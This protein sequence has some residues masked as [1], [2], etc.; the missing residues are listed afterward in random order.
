M[1]HSSSHPLIHILLQNEEAIAD[2][3]GQQYTKHK[4]SEKTLKLSN[5]K[6]NSSSN[7][8]FN[9]QIIHGETKWRLKQEAAKNIKQKRKRDKHSIKLE[10]TTIPEGMRNTFTQPV[11]HLNS[12]IYDSTSQLTHPLHDVTSSID[13]DSDSTLSSVATLPST[14]SIISS[15]ENLISSHL[16][17][18]CSSSPCKC[19][20]TFPRITSPLQQQQQTEPNQTISESISNSK[21]NSVLPILFPLRNV[22]SSDSTYN[23]WINFKEN[24]DILSP[25]AQQRKLF[26]LLKKSEQEIITEKSNKFASEGRTKLGST[27]HPDTAFQQRKILI[28][29]VNEIMLD[30]Q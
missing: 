8:Q 26:R 27:Q 6:T 19:S 1:L 5:N 14:A 2:I 11:Q 3:I 10:T 29:T 22:S 12:A 13:V 20:L 25:S 4:Q 28:M 18:D 23:Q 9:H 21:S 30:V 24:E 16:C 15:S 17:S 7:I